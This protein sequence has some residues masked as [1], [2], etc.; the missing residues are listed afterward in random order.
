MCHSHHIPRPLPTNLSLSIFSV[1][2]AAYPPAASMVWTPATSRRPLAHVSSVRQAS[3]QAPQQV[4]HTQRVGEC[5]RG[6]EEWVC[7]EG[8]AGAGLA[9]AGSQNQ[10]H[11]DLAIH[12][13]GEQG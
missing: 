2:Q 10:P 1:P 13:L 6:Q 7:K 4:P 12:A 11:R 8:G 5:G 3:T 9:L